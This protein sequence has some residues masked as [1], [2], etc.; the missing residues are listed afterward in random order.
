MTE[1]WPP[2]RTK[3]VLAKGD[4]PSSSTSPH[5]NLD[6]RQEPEPAPLA[7]RE[8]SKPPLPRCGSSVSGRCQEQWGHRPQRPGWQLHHAFLFFFF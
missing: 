6:C 1:E 8:R 4:F 2:R 5:G 3:P 7:S